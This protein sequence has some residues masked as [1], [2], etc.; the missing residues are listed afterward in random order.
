VTR[1][2]QASPEGF[3]SGAGA[4]VARNPSSDNKFGFREDQKANRDE[5]SYGWRK[6]F[7]QFEPVTGQLDA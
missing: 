1:S 4:D 6:F 2:P 7:D 3:A 5:A